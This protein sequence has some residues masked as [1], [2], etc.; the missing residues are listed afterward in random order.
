MTETKIRPADETDLERIL[1]I[2]A[3]AR[4]FMAQNGNPTQWHS[5]YPRRELL[6][7]DIRLG[8][9]YAVMRQNEICGAFVFFIGDDPTYEYID[10]SW[11]S[12][13]AYGVIHRIAGIGGGIFCAALEFCLSRIS[14]NEKRFFL[15]EYSASSRSLSSRLTS[16]FRIVPKL[17]RIGSILSV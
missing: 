2:Y 7:E 4:E 1:E 9:L 5:G 16:S 13:S 17:L 14:L 12:D 15:M 10:G 11:R 6:E 3:Y 8:R